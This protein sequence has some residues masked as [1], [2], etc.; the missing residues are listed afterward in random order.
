MSLEEKEK[1]RKRILEY[2]SKPENREA[3]AERI[4]KYRRNMAEEKKKELAR[5]LS[6]AALKAEARKTVVDRLI[7]N[8]NKSLGKKR[9]FRTPEGIEDRLHRS[10]ILTHNPIYQHKKCFQKECQGME[11][12]VKPKKKPSKSKVRIIKKRINTYSGRVTES[13]LESL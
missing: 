12:E 13:E 6:E 2:W 11:E 7:E 10:Y 9:Y 5:K 8:R 1:R 4:R 3:Q